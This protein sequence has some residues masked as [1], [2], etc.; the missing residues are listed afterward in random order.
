MNRDV[1][2]ADLQAGNY[3]V[4]GHLLPGLHRYIL[5]RVRPGAF[6]VALLENDFH[7]AVTRADDAVLPHLRC[8]ARFLHNFAPAACHGSP[9]AVE[10]WLKGDQP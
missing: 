3:L 7:G 1:V 10:A 5:D 9:A 2:E 4:P 8:L 6:L